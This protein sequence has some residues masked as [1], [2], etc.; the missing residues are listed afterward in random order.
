VENSQNMLPGYARR[1]GKRQ[2]RRED[3]TEIMQ[4]NVQVSG[5]GFYRFPL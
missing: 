1:K 3:Q 5:T 4:A 2:K